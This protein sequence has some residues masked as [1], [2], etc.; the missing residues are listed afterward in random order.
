M[1]LLLLAGGRISSLHELNNCIEVVTSVIKLI[2]VLGLDQ[3][4]YITQLQRYTSAHGSR[5][6]TIREVT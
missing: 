4:F 3:E 5:W 6:C 1:L 2:S